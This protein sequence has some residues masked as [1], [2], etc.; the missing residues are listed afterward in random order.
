ML[1]LA[2]SIA[3]QLVKDLQLTDQG[4]DWCGIVSMMKEEWDQYT[5]AERLV[6][7]SLKSIRGAQQTSVITLF[8]SLALL[9]EDTCC[10]PEVC[11]LMYEVGAGI[12][13]SSEEQ[14]SMSRSR[15][16]MQVRRWMKCLI[17][18]SI[19]LGTVDRPQLH[20]IVR[21]HVIGLHTEEE[22]QDMHRR[23][24]DVF[25]DNRPVGPSGEKE[26]V[27]TDSSAMSRYIKNNIHEH[28]RLGWPNEESNGSTV[29]LAWLED[30][31]QDTIVKA[32]AE[33]L[34]AEEL[35]RM[36]TTA[37][38]TDNKQWTVCKLASLAGWLFQQ[39]KTTAEEHETATVWMQKAVDGLGQL[40]G[41][42]DTEA[43]LRQQQE[44]LEIICLERLVLSLLGG[45]AKAIKENEDRIKLLA[46]SSAAMRQPAAAAIL[47]FS[48]SQVVALD[49][50]IDM[51]PDKIAKFQALFVQYPLFLTS[52]IRNPESNDQ[53]R[54]NCMFALHNTG[55]FQC[56]LRHAGFDWDTFYGPGGAFLLGAM[57]EYDF[58]KHH[59]QAM[60]LG[61]D[62][63][64]TGCVAPW[65]LAC[66]YG[67]VEQSV[68]VLE[69]CCCILERIQLEPN[70]FLYSMHRC[71]FGLF[72]YETHVSSARTQSFT[73]GL[74]F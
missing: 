30:V 17:D 9:P 23:F 7:V 18:R 64:G 1:P 67:E 32:V 40:A 5:I 8:K 63:M 39:S 34:G 47:L 55:A 26:W 25:R 48:L 21:D 52:C 42:G 74:W 59:H 41:C 11:V 73:L 13:S 65:V 44:Q 14:A 2:I 4:S 38:S 35:Q 71:C 29:I 51:D 70:Q 61:V 24:V 46:H 27:N 56:V 6:D 37:E 68:S 53:M 19:V 60:S 50:V 16:V 10:P 45:S 33:H 54:Q 49:A 43:T 36:C 15:R 58:D 3:G 28:I 72:W 22:L 20:D 66:H 31:P 62:N 12:P 69:D 57:Q